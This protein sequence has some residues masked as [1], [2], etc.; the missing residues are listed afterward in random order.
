SGADRCGGP[1]RDALDARKPPIFAHIAL[2]GA[3]NV[4]SPASDPGV[5]AG[6]SMAESNNLKRA[7]HDN[8]PFAE[9]ERIMG[10]GASARDTQAPDPFELD[11]ERELLG[12]FTDEHAAPA[13]PQSG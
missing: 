13:M 11:L 2:V 5:S 9:L 10:T 4:T 1:R 7:V 12:E 6:S 3:G 8:D